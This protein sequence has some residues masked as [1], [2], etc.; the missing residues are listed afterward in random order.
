MWKNIL[1]PHDFSPCADR[2]L[3]LAVEL[4]RVHRA[5]LSILHV[6]DLPENL[7]RDAIVLP[8]GERSA[9]PATEHATR[10]ALRRLEQIAGPLRS[11]GLSVLTRA[12][13]GDVADEIL[14][15]AQD[16]GADAL[17]VGTHGRAGLSHL[18]LGSVAE[19]LVRHAPVPVVTLRSPSPEAEPTRE[20]RDAEDEL[21]G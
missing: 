1:V 4:A 11:E 6:S 17:V 10:G 13:T 19:K 3:L 14:G 15:A 18:L 8:P 5:G 20:E 21:A 7:A 2:A 9:L 16:L 12:V